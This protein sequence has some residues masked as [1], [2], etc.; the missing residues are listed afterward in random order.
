MAGR[1]PEGGAPSPRGEIERSLTTTYRRDLWAPFVAA[2]QRYE[3]IAPGDRIA[4]CISGG[5]DSMLMGKLLQLLLRHSDF[6]FDVTYLVMDPGYSPENRRRIMENAALLGLPVTVF[7][8]DIFQAV[9]AGEKNPCY[10]CARM[11]RGHLYRQAQELGC[12]KI[13]LGHHRN[14]AIETTLLA[15]LYGGQL[16]GMMPKLRS[17]HFPGME[18]IRPLYRVREADILRWTRRHGLS[19]LQCACRLTEAGGQGA[20]KRQEVKELLAQLCREDPDVEKRLFQS[21]HHLHSETF[22]GWKDRAGD[23]SF[24]ENYG[25]PEAGGDE[26]DQI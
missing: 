6:P 13:A 26:G 19:F 23:H 21:L 22:P 20:S 11:R 12:N 14:D 2:V 4:A 18:L 1:G 7:E 10:R 24:L 3:L 9:G 17:R 16:Q 5:K 25:P 8:T 15:M